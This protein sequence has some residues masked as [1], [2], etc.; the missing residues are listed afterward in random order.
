MLDYLPMSL[1]SGNFRGICPSCNGLIHRRVSLAQIDV[2]KGVCT[3]AYP[4]GQQRLVDTSSPSPDCHF[5][6]ADLKP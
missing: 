4:H 2:A 5:E 3:V 1:V 6:Q